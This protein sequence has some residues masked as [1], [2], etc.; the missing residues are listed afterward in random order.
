M[1]PRPNKE[2]H[3]WDGKN[4]PQFDVLSFQD[5]GSD[6]TNTGDPST[7]AEE[8]ILYVKNGVLYYRRKSSGTIGFDVAFSDGTAAL[9]SVTNTLDT[10][11]GMFWPGANQL[12]LTAKG[13]EFLRVDGVTDLTDGVVYLYGSKEATSSTVGAVVITGGV[14][15]AKKLYVGGTAEIT[16][17]S[18][19]TGDATFAGKI[20]NDDTTDAT[21]TTA[22]AIQTDGGV[23]MA[24]AL[25]VGEISTHVG[26]ASFAAGSATLPSIARTGDLNTGMFFQDADSIGFATVGFEVARFDGVT[27]TDAIV[28]FFGS[29]D[30]SNSTTGSIVMTGGLA[31]AKKLYVGTDVDISGTITDLQ[32]QYQY[33]QPK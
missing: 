11:T 28:T 13:V 2:S 20:I 25:W 4:V 17:V 3:T 9:P 8:S 24:K 1:A 15:I 16:G 30:A 22:G 23:A 7:S 32:L 27:L 21:S 18:T 33:H 10:D 31:I 26:I 14:G 12:G 5:R 19:L 29:L 6:G